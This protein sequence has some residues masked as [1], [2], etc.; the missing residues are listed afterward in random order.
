[1]RILL[2]ENLNWRLERFLPGHE[3]RSVPLLGWAGLKNG[4]LLQRA[5]DEGFDVLLTMDGSMASQQNL[6]TIRLA[7]IALRAVS[8]RL[9]DTSPL[10]PEVL[11]LLP[12]LQPGQVIEVG[13]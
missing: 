13:A 1:M 5:A 10:M 2:D 12:T 3:V 4:R 7:V 9:E 8:N 6:S 11:A